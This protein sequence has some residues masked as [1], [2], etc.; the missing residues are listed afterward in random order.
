MEKRILSI[1]KNSYDGALYNYAVHVFTRRESFLFLR[2]YNLYIITCFKKENLFQQQNL[3]IF[4]ALLWNINKKKIGWS[5][6]VL[7]Q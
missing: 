5:L 2:I 4:N 7:L 1:Y 6:E 3:N